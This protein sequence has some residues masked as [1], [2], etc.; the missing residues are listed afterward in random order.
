LLAGLLLTKLSLSVVVQHGLDGHGLGESGGLAPLEEEGAAR[1]LV[2]GQDVLRGLRGRGEGQLGDR[3][4]GHGV[5][6]VDALVGPR[7]DDAAAQKI[8]RGRYFAE[9]YPKVKLYFLG[10]R[11]FQRYPTGGAHGDEVLFSW[12]M[13]HN[14]PPFV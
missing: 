14:S 12:R 4:C 5:H 7:G 8:L 1:V 2:D 9:G 3:V 6:F 10:I 11:K 13:G